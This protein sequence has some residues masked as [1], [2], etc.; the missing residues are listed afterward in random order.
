V[1]NLPP[2]FGASDFG[3]AG[4][5]ADPAS[6]DWADASSDWGSPGVGSMGVVSSLTAHL[7]VVRGVVSSP[8]NVG[9]I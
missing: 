5:G 2:N 1:L 7:V 9:A 4:V 8:E 6:S 3:A